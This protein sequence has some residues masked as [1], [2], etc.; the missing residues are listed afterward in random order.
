MLGYLDHSDLRQFLVPNVH[1]L[2]VARDQIAF[3]TVATIILAGYVAD[4][5][6]FIGIECLL[7]FFLAFVIFSVSW[8]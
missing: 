3:V 1:R 5:E 4:Y 8:D 7:D 2:N 6:V